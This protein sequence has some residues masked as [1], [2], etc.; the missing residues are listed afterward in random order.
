MCWWTILPW[1]VKSVCVKAE[2]RQKASR[3]KS[4]RSLNDIAPV[5]KIR[6]ALFVARVHKEIALLR[7]AKVP[8]RFF[9][10]PT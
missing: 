8:R 5:Y 2:S 7:N 4:W 1:G 3:L 9:F 10:F 6:F